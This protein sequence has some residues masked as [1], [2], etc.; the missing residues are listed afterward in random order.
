MIIFLSNFDFSE[1]FILS[2]FL[3]LK[4]NFIKLHYD[5]FMGFKNK[6]IS[7]ENDIRKNGVGSNGLEDDIMRV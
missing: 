3:E 5:F 2:L 4:R 7:H 6:K 1:F